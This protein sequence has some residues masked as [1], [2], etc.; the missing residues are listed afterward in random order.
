MVE[1]YSYNPCKEHREAIIYLTKYLKNT[2]HI[3]LCCKPDT[4]EDFEYSIDAAFAGMWNLQFAH[5]NPDTTSL[6]KDVLSST[7]DALS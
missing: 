7:L 3:E 1:K 5:V 4:R 2:R 6:M